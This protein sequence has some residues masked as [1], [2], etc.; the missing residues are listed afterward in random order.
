MPRKLQ[1]LNCY[2]EMVTNFYRYIN[3]LLSKIMEVTVFMHDVVFYTT[4]FERK[5]ETHMT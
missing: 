5:K 3:V 2:V 4:Y 1:L